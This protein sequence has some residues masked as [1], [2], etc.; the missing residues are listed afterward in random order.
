MIMC[1][2]QGYPLLYYPW[3][4]VQKVRKIRFH[5]GKPAYSLEGAIKEF[6]GSKQIFSTDRALKI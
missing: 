4:I 5:K 3:K 2:S 6:S 1:M